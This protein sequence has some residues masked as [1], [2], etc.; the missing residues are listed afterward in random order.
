L[1]DIR[2]IMKVLP[3]RYPF[4]LVDRVLELEPGRRCRGL[5]AVT[6]NEPCF[7]G[8][9][10]DDPIMPGVLIV[11]FMAQVG[12]LV[13]YP[14]R[15]R[16]LLQ[17]FDGIK[18]LSAVTPGDVLEA[19]AVLVKRFGRLGRVRATAAVGDHRV[20]R[21]EITYAFLPSGGG[22]GSDDPTGRER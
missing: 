13:F 6:V 18:F 4:L 1:M 16:I 9:F 19:E 5:K 3:H 11:E 2:E 14:S 17:G 10:P 21:G 15:D 22:P 20:C 7:A 8:H 12:G